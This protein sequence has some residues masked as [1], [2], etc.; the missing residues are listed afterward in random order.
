MLM[1]FQKLV[2]VISPM[3]V[4]IVSVIS[5]MGLLIGFG[6]PVH[7]MSSMI[8]IFLMPISVVDSVHVLSEFFDRYTK[9]KGRKE[10]IMEVM[11]SLFTP[12][13]YTSLTS[14]AGFLSLALTP[15]P[16]VQVFGV[17]VA[18]GIMIAWV[19]TVTF[20]PAYV[21][22]VREKSLG[23]FGLEAQ[24]G[25]KRTWLT[26]LLHSA[27]RVTYSNAKPI[28]AIFVVVVVIAV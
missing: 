1:F 8:P 25:Q 7:I 20:V 26:R 9:S 27:G 14:A 15:I 16:P 12:M 19:C 21:M 6:Y 5:T 2:L 4:A 18:L 10:T 24:H 22:L 3:I 23:N 11:D 28:L 17:F 13:L